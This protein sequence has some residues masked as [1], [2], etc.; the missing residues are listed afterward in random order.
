[1]VN[2]VYVVEGLEMMVADVVKFLAKD[3]D[4]ELN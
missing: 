4:N 2:E 1:V 3:G